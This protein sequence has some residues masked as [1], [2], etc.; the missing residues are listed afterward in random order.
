M[1]SHQPAKFGGHKQCE[2]G[3]IMFL[4]AQEQDSTW[5]FIFASPTFF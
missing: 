1:V 5:P 2:S 4:V 3:H